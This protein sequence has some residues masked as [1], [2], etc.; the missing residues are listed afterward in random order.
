MFNATLAIDEHLIPFDDTFILYNPKDIISIISAYFSLLPIL[1]L[2]FY[3]SWLIITREIESCIIAG[4]QLANEFLNKILKRLIKQ[5]RPY[6]SLLGPGYGMPS[7]HSQFVGFMASY[8]TL[9]ILFKWKT[10]NKIIKIIHILII[11]LISII[12]C[13]SRI[14]LKYH[15][16]NQVIVG[17]SVGLMNGTLYFLTI[18]IIRNLGIIDWLLTFKIMKLMYIKDTCNNNPITLEEEYINY[19]KYIAAKENNN[20]NNNDNDYDNRNDSKFIKKTL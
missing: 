1:V 12:T 7:A 20:N 10:S 5:P 16:W 18:D 17:I 19:R 4:G 11:N 6:Q 14:Y 2:T 9:R 13:Y 3:L 15:N 8:I